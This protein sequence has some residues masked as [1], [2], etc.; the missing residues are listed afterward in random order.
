[1]DHRYDRLKRY[2]DI[3]RMSELIYDWKRYWCLRDG[4]GFRID[5]NGFL[6]RSEYFKDTFE[7]ASIAHIPCLVLLGEPGIREEPRHQRSGSFCFGI[8]R[9]TQM[10]LLRFALVWQRGPIV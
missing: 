1:M 8:T 4:R 7:F 5:A 6:V 9:G 3:Q 10:F 2:N